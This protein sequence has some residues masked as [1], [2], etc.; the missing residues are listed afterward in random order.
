MYLEGLLRDSNGQYVIY[1]L[2]FILAPDTFIRMRTL[3]RLQALFSPAARVHAR[4]LS[5]L[6]VPFGERKQGCC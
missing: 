5:P 2:V 4:P 3:P 1:C 6:Y